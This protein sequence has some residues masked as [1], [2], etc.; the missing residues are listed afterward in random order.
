MFIFFI[1]SLRVLVN[2]TKTQA[3]RTFDQSSGFGLDLFKSFALRAILLK[4]KI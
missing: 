1:Q 3:E 2:I 4:G